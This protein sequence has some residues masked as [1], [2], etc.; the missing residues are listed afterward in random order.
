MSG[1]EK[2]RL[3]ELFKKG[4]ENAGPDL[5]YHEP[6]WDAM[7]QLLDAH[8]KQPGIIYWL[9]RFG[10]VA[11]V[12][13]VFLGWWL[14]KPTGVKPQQ[15]AVKQQPAA[16]PVIPDKGSM[17]KNQDRAVNAAGQ[18]KGVTGT[19]HSSIG[20]AAVIRHQ[21]APKKATYALSLLKPLIK[22]LVNEQ[23]GVAS[24]GR[25]VA[26]NTAP[27]KQVS[28][29]DSI[30]NANQV[31]KAPAG[32]N[33][34]PLAETHLQQGITND[35]PNEAADDKPKKIK[36][37][38]AGFKPRLGLTVLASPDIN[39]VGSFRQPQ[40]GTNIGLLVSVNIT[41]KLSVSTGASY[42][43]KPY[44]TN[45]SNY[46]TNYKFKTDPSNVYADCRVLDIPLNVDYQLYSKNRN[47]FSVGSGLSS[48]IML[49]EQYTYD[50]SA[51]ASGPQGY[52][53]RNKNQHI[54]GVLNLNATYQRALNSRFSLAAEPYLKI[55][56][57]NIGSSQVRLRSAG[58]AIGLKW[59]IGQSI[60]P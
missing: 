15:V 13:L 16:T 59:N 58:V 19:Q 31:N 37:K 28:A 50:Y 26:A 56:L 18:Q 2:S 60:T 40:V 6:D 36:V 17:A 32:T 52:T 54:L 22:P 14:F 53:V 10:A 44:E 42:S 49:K 51:S 20:Y 1:E 24:A 39:G 5:N 27:Q 43:R 12:L 33:M 41:S 45:F 30:N 9:P 3:D 57:T 47:S 21:A 11:A 48:Y 4:L 29:T 35:A 34:E 46:H 55:P 23:Q 8:K 38:N 25:A 7:E